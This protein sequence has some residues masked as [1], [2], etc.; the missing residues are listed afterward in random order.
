M[1]LEG[2]AS[3]KYDITDILSNLY[4]SRM[5][6][7]P[8]GTKMRLIPTLEDIILPTTRDEVYPKLL[9]GQVAFA[10]RVVAKK[11][12]VFT[13]TL[14]IDR[15]VDPTSNKTLRGLIMDVPSLKVPGC[16]LF[17]SVDKT[18]RSNSMVIFT[19]M[20][21]NELDARMF[22]EGLIPYLRDQV[23]PCFLSSF[24]NKAQV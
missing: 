20:P 2:P 3:R 24:T 12:Q 8:D 9:A 11:T 14:K 18:W 13:T 4:G 15:T 5:K 10:A 22:I 6:N 17:H 1:H 23:D 7:F 16:P 19:V 21:Q